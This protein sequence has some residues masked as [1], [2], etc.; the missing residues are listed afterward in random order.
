LVESLLTAAR[1]ALNGGV[2]Y[3]MLFITG[4]GMLAVVIAVLLPRITFSKTQPKENVAQL[5]NE[6]APA[7]EL[8]TP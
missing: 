2:H 1:F 6:S 3:G 5:E 8:V 4:C 7:K